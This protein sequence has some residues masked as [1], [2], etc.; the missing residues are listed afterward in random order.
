[1][2]DVHGEELSFPQIYY[3]VPRQFDLNVRVTPYMMATSEIRRTDRRGA[4]PDHVLYM[5]MKILRIRVVEDEIASQAAEI[6]NDVYGANTVTANYVKFW[7]RRFRSGIFDVKDAP[8]TCKPVVKNVD[9]ITE[10]IG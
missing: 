2:Y 6:L 3:G 10:I 9:K 7:F 5:A 4:T 8:R 1:M